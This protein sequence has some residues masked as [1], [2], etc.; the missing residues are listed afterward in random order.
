[1][2][3]TDALLINIAEFDVILIWIE[4]QETSKRATVRSLL[5]LFS[6]V[7]F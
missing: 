5:K 1:M 3:F 2:A 7:N 4:T 6:V